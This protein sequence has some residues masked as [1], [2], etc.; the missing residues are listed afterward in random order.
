MSE[1]SDLPCV[2]QELKKYK[3]RVSKYSCGKLHNNMEI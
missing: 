3:S 2:I 1:I